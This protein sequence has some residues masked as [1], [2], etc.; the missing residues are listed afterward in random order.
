MAPRRFVAA[1]AKYDPNRVLSP[2]PAVF[3][4]K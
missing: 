3:G 4:E 2:H 1:K